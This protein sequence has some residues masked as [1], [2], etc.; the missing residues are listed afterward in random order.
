VTEIL[1]SA[2]K[3][4]TGL[5]SI[6]LP[7]QVE[8]IG[9]EAFSGCKNL[10]TVCFGSGLTRIYDYAFAACDGLTA[11]ILPDDIEYIGEL[12][13]ANCSN[14]SSVTIGKGIR[15][16]RRLA[17]SD[18][19]ALEDFYCYAET[20]PVG[21]PEGEEIIIFYDSYISSATLHVPASAIE[22][23]SSTAPWSE[24]GQIVAIEGTD[25]GEVKASTS[26]VDSTY[27]N[28]GGIRVIQPKRGIYIKD[29]RKYLKK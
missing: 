27:Y 28:L 22:T 5:T 19:R 17:F 29:G 9:T 16:I 24:F 10:G 13:F 15:Y 2:F 3:D 21:M 11:V 20:P 7:D 4:C 1:E 12:A 23:Y 25:I 26:S 8:T 14:L 6:T 18:C